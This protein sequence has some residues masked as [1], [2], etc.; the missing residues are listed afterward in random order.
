MIQIDQGS[1]KPLETQEDL[2][3]TQVAKSMAFRDQKKQQESSVELPHFARLASHGGLL[4]P[5][6]LGPCWSSSSRWVDLY[7]KAQL[8]PPLL[9][10][11]PKLGLLESF[12]WNLAK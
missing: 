10:F 3:L 5:A 11:P 4:P 9:H 12:S 1:Q 6:L 8:P 7:S 2:G